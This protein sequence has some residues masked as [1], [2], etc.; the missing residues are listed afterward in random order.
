MYLALPVPEAIILRAC[1][2][3]VPSGRGMVP[4]PKGVSMSL[5]R[6]SKK[7]QTCSHEHADRVPAV[8]ERMCKEQDH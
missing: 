1:C 4:Y 6:S 2:P 8:G 7:S 5:T 3:D